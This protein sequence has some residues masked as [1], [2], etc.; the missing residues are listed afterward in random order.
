M[1][2]KEDETVSLNFISESQEKLSKIT[3]HL[4]NSKDIKINFRNKSKD[5]LKKNT[6]DNQ[7]CSEKLTNQQGKS[8][9]ILSSINHQAI[10]NSI[11]VYVRCKPI[12]TPEKHNS[13]NPLKKDIVKVDENKLYICNP[14]L[15]SGEI[16]SDNLEI[17]KQYEFDNILHENSTNLGIFENCIAPYLEDFLL[18]YNLSI[19][20][21]GITGAGKTYTMF[22]KDLCTDDAEL[23]EN[24]FENLEEEELNIYQTKKNNEENINNDTNYAENNSKGIV[25]YF[26]K[27]LLKEK[28]ELKKSKKTSVLETS[29][30]SKEISN[31]EISNQ[32]FS[33]LRKKSVDNGNLNQ[34][35]VKNETDEISQDNLVSSQ[36]NQTIQKMQNTDIPEQF[37]NLNQSVSNKQLLSNNKQ[38]HTQKNEQNTIDNQQKDS[39]NEES[40]DPSY[41]FPPSIVNLQFDD[42]TKEELRL[43]TQ[44]KSHLSNNGKNNET[45]YNEEELKITGSFYE[46]YNEQIRDLQTD[47]NEKSNPQNLQIIENDEKGVMVNNLTKVEI[48][49]IND[50]NKILL[51]GSRQRIKAKTQS[52]EFSSRSHALVEIRIQRSRVTQDGKIQAIYGKA[53][54]VDLAGSERINPNYNEHNDRRKE[55]ANI[56][57]SLLSLANCIS[58]L[59]D[60]K[61]G[62]QNWRDSKLTR[63]LKDT[64][65]GNSQTIMISCINREAF[66]YENTVNTLNYT[67]KAKNINKEVKKT[68]IEYDADKKK[69]V[70]TET[71][72]VVNPN[73]QNLTSL[74][75]KLLASN[76]RKQVKS[77]RE[78]SL[79]NK[80]NLQHKKNLLKNEIRN[81]TA[82][83]KHSIMPR[84]NSDEKN[85]LDSH[86][87]LNKNFKV[88]TSQDSTFFTKEEKFFEK[89]KKEY[90]TGGSTM[91]DMLDLMK[92]LVDK[93]KEVDQRLSTIKNTKVETYIYFEKS[94]K[95]FLELSYEIVNF[96]KN[97]FD[98]NMSYNEMRMTNT[99]KEIQLSSSNDESYFGMHGLSNKDLDLKM[100]KNSYKNF[101]SSPKNQPFCFSQ[102]NNYSKRFSLEKEYK[103]QYFAS[104]MSDSKTKAYKEISKQSSKYDKTI[105]YKNSKYNSKQK[106]GYFRNKIRGSLDYEEPNNTE[107]NTEQQ[108][109]HHASDDNIQEYHEIYEYF[110]NQKDYNFYDK[111]TKE[112]ICIE[113]NDFQNNTLQNMTPKKFSL[114]PTHVSY[115]KQQGKQFK[116]ENKLKYDKDQTKSKHVKTSKNNLKEPFIENT[117]FS[118]SFKDKSCMSSLAY[119]GYNKSITKSKQTPANTIKIVQNAERIKNNMNFDKNP[120]N[121]ACSNSQTKSTQ[122]RSNN[123]L[124]TS[125]NQKKMDTRLSLTN[126]SQKI[127]TDHEKLQKECNKIV[128][129]FVSNSK[130]KNLFYGNRNVTSNTIKE[131]DQSPEKLKSTVN[132]KTRYSN[133]IFSNRIR[134]NEGSTSFR[135]SSN[136]LKQAKSDKK[137]F[138]SVIPEN[139]LKLH[140]VIPNSC[141]SPDVNYYQNCY[142]KKITTDKINK[143]VTNQSLKENLRS[144]HNELSKKLYSSS[145]DNKK[146]RNSYFLVKNDEDHNKAF[147]SVNEDINNLQYSSQQSSY[148][149]DIK[150]T[151]NVDKNVY[152]K[153]HNIDV[154]SNE[155][156]SPEVDKILYNSYYKNFDNG[157]YKEKRPKILSQEFYSSNNTNLL[158]VVSNERN[159][160]S[161]KNK[162]NMDFKNNKKIS[163]K[164]KKVM[165]TKNIQS[166]KKCN[167]RSIKEDFEFFHN[168]NI[169]N[170]EKKNDQVLISINSLKKP[171]QTSV[172][173]NSELNINTNTNQ[174]ID[175]TT[176]NNTHFNSAQ[177]SLLNIPNET[178]IEVNNVKHQST[179]TSVI[180]Y[181]KSCIN[182]YSRDSK[183]NN[184]QES[185]NNADL[186]KLDYARE[187]FR[188]FKR[189]LNDFLHDL[190]KLETSQNLSKDIN[191][192]YGKKHSLNN[193]KQIK[194][195]QLKSFNQDSLRNK[196]ILLLSEYKNSGYSYN[197][198]QEQLE[199]IKEATS[200][201]PEDDMLSSDEYADK[202]SG[203]IGSKTSKEE[204]LFA[205]GTH[206]DISPQP[207][208]NRSLRDVKTPFLQTEPRK[209]VKT[210][211]LEERNLKNLKTIN[212]H[213]NG[214][215]FNTADSKNSGS[216]N[217]RASLT[218]ENNYTNP[219]KA[220]QKEKIDAHYNRDSIA[221]LI[222]LRNEQNIIMDNE[223]QTS[224]DNFEN[225]KEYLFHES[226]NPVIDIYNGKNSYNKKKQ[227]SDVIV[228]EPTESYKFND[229]IPTQDIIESPKAPEGLMFFKGSLNSKNKKYEPLFHNSNHENSEKRVRLKSKST[230]SNNRID[231]ITQNSNSPLNHFRMRRDLK[232]ISKSKDKEEVLS[233]RGNLG[234]KYMQQK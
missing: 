115:S 207:I 147:G 37:Q 148:I 70:E 8:T 137:I 31:L 89:L 167:L 66:N 80:K 83:E 125:Y 96:L 95:K 204:K 157:T 156:Q 215:I 126:A 233:Y 57:K 128:N 183:R 46:I 71:L 173:L 221:D 30:K 26:I 172:Q 42:H 176:K 75:L 56:N 164:N 63:I 140:K 6:K 142:M 102:K 231:S 24:M 213:D 223:K 162:N 155:F 104:A 174:T 32:K 228:T 41:Q 67:V 33:P 212:L 52:N 86:H 200:L 101:S 59:S 219:Y 20:C 226:K 220:I 112:V 94:S 54:L 51:I 184:Y 23:T 186:R 151:N 103:H 205:F 74:K 85:L 190:K 84:K 28:D 149:L 98:E 194:A 79:K 171:N 180:D 139:D 214:I 222:E 53:L 132:D 201:L 153:G 107:C 44:K 193:L 106:L 90:Q 43:N 152:Y 232:K 234:L 211:N 165:S 78:I 50:F 179:S 144:I 3:K 206:Y 178:E 150:D 203:L 120:N 197:L 48:E 35:Q 7:V 108:K 127:N 133:R 189:L 119:Q 100:N 224:D 21:Y 210:K 130:K 64:L 188:S 97:E 91:A 121:S 68:T 161:N 187:K 217:R 40:S 92:I 45:S 116:V 105:S 82:F 196:A 25:Y 191:N 136:D 22:G 141:V 169:K 114:S 113:V 49:N 225:N 109:R 159:T 34:Q 138:K 77:A 29:K 36:E 15:M 60:K 47:N 154:I 88:D 198:K 73:L 175:N 143:K 181:P 2:N 129:S 9:N 192:I 76:K 158:N 118:T 135:Q 4:K 122:L 160:F 87:P 163:I 27:N 1:Y 111:K 177:N 39:S 81:T 134:A 38:Q 124:K 227:M 10:S 99:D 58:K 229:R 93:K 5:F 12:I 216:L 218:S 195:E 182:E 11:K 131:T 209:N 17:S 14:I 230:V 55:G 123:N 166:D 65:G 202:L 168:K 110:R 170:R 199:I 16:M 146:K 13:D 69:E 117:V 61:S 62:Y 145:N 18:G 72:G 208:E 19:M 185:D